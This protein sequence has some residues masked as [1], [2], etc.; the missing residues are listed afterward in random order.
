MQAVAELMEQGTG[1]VRGQQRGLTV[2]A[3]AKLQTLMIKGATWP[4]SFCWSRSDVIQRAER[5]DDRA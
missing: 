4:S 2:G 3:L 1:V 5:L